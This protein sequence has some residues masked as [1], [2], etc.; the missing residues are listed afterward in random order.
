MDVISFQA[1]ATEAKATESAAG[2]KAATEEAAAAGSTT[3][4][5]GASGPKTYRT[6]KEG[7][8]IMAVKVVRSIIIT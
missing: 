8:E 6:V 2:A 7:R 3:A 5:E 1:G 4:G